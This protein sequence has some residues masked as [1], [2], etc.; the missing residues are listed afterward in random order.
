MFG[1]W[2]SARGASP[3]GV[4]GGGTPEAVAPP[5]SLGQATNIEVFTDGARPPAPAV[6]A[7]ASP[8]ASS[9]P[10]T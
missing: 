10:V 2:V 8:A 3:L 1:E 4:T 7:A 5:L 9:A 6:D